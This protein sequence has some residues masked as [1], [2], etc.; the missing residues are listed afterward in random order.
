ML[1][2]SCA[3]QTTKLHLK[4][5]NKLTRNVCFRLSSASFLA[6][7]SSS[8]CRCSS[9]SRSWIVMRSFLQWKNQASHRF[10]EYRLQ[11]DKQKQFHVSKQYNL[12]TA[13]SG[14]HPA[15]FTSFMI[16]FKFCC[17]R[18]VFSLAL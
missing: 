2:V 11:E 17:H 16:I 12:K 7:A 5:L 18:V 8:F 13:Y 9:R 14:N 10:N 6:S 3:L 1:R 15:T 4:M